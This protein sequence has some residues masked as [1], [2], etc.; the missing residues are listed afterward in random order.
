MTNK[1]KKPISLILSLLILISAIPMAIVAA[2]DTA[3]TVEGMTDQLYYM[4][5]ETVE[6]IYTLV[7]ITDDSGIAGVSLDAV[8]YNE[9]AL[10]LVSVAKVDLP[11]GWELYGSA[12]PF[13]IADDT[14]K[15][16]I[17]NALE[18]SFKLVFHIL[19]SANDGKY[20]V[21]L[22][23]S[24]TN[25]RLNEVWLS[26][27]PVDI[28]VKSGDGVAT[29][30][31]SSDNMSYK[32]GET[33]RIVFSLYSIFDETGISGLSID[34][35]NYDDTLLEFISTEKNSVPSGW[36]LY[37]DA[38]PFMIADD[39]G[40]NAV[41]NDNLITFVLTLKVKNIS[42]DENTLITLEGSGTNGGL[43]EV[44]INFKAFKMSVA[45]GPA[46]DKFTPS[47]AFVFG[48]P[49]EEDGTIAI[50][51]Y[52][53]AFTEVNIAPEY[54]IDGNKCAISSIDAEA[55]YGNEELLSVIIPD[56]VESIGEAAFYD[57]TALKK[58][59]LLGNPEIGDV[60]VGFY[61]TGTARKPVDTVVDGFTLYA[62]SGD[63]TIISNAQT[64]ALANGIAF[65]G[66]ENFAYKGCQVSNDIKTADKFNIR[67]AGIIDSLD[68]QKVGFDIIVAEYEKSW[69]SES[70]KVY[71]SLKGTTTDGTPITAVTAEELGGEYITAVVIKDVPG[72]TAMSFEV[73]PY[74]VNVLGAKVYGEAWNVNVSAE[75]VVTNVKQ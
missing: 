75:G 50:I 5:S 46:E 43:N 10:E 29:I 52:I 74:V 6:I 25:G 18:L 63:E 57:C 22:V 4:P 49:N 13:M 15:T 61:N 45:A 24:G 55:F 39:S 12:D 72:Q 67:F 3:A 27:E 70:N 2:A 54:E 65:E 23:G 17:F 31:G 28:I 71:K 73:N 64:Y 16:P 48:E 53:G 37:G 26:L 33:V 47:S 20:T 8:E 11:D 7:D 56:S 42:K 30:S 14:G 69:V 40:K 41:K 34:K 32:S 44:E 68:Y 66:L 35:I 36:E 9:S 21:N 38:A 59:T 1:Q 60:A 62:W 58:V 19:P 51:E